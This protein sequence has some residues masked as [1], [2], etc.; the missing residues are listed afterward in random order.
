MM[1]L[2]SP[3]K[4]ARHLQ[5]VSRCRSDNLWAFESMAWNEMAY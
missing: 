5:V 3:H 1:L 2:S 4:G